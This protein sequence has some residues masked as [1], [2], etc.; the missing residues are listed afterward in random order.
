MEATY[1]AEDTIINSSAPWFLQKGLR[2]ESLLRSYTDSMGLFSSG[3]HLDVVTTF[4][5]TSCDDTVK[6]SFTS[7]SHLKIMGECRV[8]SSFEDR[9]IA[10][11]S[12]LMWKFGCLYHPKCVPL[13]MDTE[14]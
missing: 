9:C 2:D 13:W 4:K 6:E 14:L 3:L 7:S 12:T 11:G 8:L 10:L 5:W 1:I